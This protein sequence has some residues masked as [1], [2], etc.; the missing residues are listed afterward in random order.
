M[1]PVITAT[2]VAI[3]TCFALAPAA[4]AYSVSAQSSCAS[5]AKAIKAGEKEAMSLKEDRDT[6]AAKVE[7]AGENWE[8]A[9]AMRNFSKEDA[10]RAHETK[11]AYKK[12]KADLREFEA[13][14]QDRVSDLNTAVAVYNRKCA[15]D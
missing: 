7:T 11:A 2:F 4:G 6:L 15:S 5:Q 12:L 8:N 3:S 14:L 10:A 1:K 9:E 13:L